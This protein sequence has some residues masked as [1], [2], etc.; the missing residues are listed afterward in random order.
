MLALAAELANEQKPPNARQL[1]GIML[2]NALHAKVINLP[3]KDN[4]QNS[5]FKRDYFYSSFLDSSNNRKQNE[6]RTWLKSGWLWIKTLVPK[7]NK[8]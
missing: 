2:K 8:R 6:R 1:A 4:K 3:S 7:S 5:F